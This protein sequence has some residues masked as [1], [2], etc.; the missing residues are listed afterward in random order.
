MS[1][2]SML[3]IYMGVVTQNSTPDQQP[4]PVPPTFCDLDVPLLLLE[5]RGTDPKALLSIAIN[6]SLLETSPAFTSQPSLL[7]DTTQ[8]SL[9]YPTRTLTMSSSSLSSSVYVPEKLND[10]PVYGLCL[11]GLV[12][13]SLFANVLVALCLMGVGRNKRRF[14]PVQEED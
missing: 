10:L 2:F 1:S 3:P 12:F 13:F 7:R 9:S 6:S 11:I 14:I 8:F 4:Q 5:Q